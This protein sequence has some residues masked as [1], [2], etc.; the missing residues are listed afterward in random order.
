VSVIQTSVRA[1]LTTFP[2]DMKL[3]AVALVVAAMNRDNL[4][5]KDKQD[6]KRYAAPARIDESVSRARQCV[7]TLVVEPDDDW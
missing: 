2:E 6:S 4:P 1:L 7:A 5:S 3:P